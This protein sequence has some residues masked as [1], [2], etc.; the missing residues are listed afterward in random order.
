MKV[1]KID[2]TTVAVQEE[3]RTMSMDEYVAFVGQQMT[4]A[5][6]QLDGHQ[7][8]VD[9]ARA[10]I[11]ALQKQLDALAKADAGAVIAADGTVAVQADGA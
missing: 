6:K 4:D 2:E 11:D 1:K 3:A 9:E 10:T 7:R 8:Y 5:Q